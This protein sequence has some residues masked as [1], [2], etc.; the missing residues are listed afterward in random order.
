[1]PTTGKRKTAL[2]TGASSGMGKAIAQRLIKDGYL[3]YVAARSVDKM[4]DL[5]RLGAEP[6]RMDLSRDDEIVD[7]VKFILSRTGGVDVLV[8]NAGFGLYGPVEEISIDEARYQFEVNLFGAARLTQLLLPAMRARRSGYIVNITSM[9][10]KMYS[11]LGAWYH[12]TKHALEGWSDCLRLE[13]AEFGIKVVIVEPGVIETGFGDAATDSIVKRSASG[14]YGRLVQMVA[15]SIKKTY[16]HG[17]GSDPRV[18]ADVVS[19]AVSSRKPRTRYA[20]GKFAKML[21]RM[22][23]W[24]GDRMFDR[25]ILSQTR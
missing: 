6:L 14:P 25:I 1:M 2:V 20:A 7:G 12:A 10:G 3:V 4:D 18:I 19:K 8:N 13:V 5:A 11:I 15:K 24:L 17:T 21:I 9:G 22:R 16:G 23:V